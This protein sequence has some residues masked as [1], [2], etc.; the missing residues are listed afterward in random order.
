MKSC[1][2]DNCDRRHAAKGMCG[3]HYNRFKRYGDTS[4]VNPPHSKGG[5][6]MK[7]ETHPRWKGRDITYVSAHCRVS[8]HRGKASAHMCACG[9]AAQEWAYDYSDPNP[10]IGDSRGEYGL[11]YSPDVERYTPMCGKCHRQFDREAGQVPA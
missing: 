6:R 5:C 4:T 3:M 9:S 11:A 8:S 7:G 1:T 10:L 2:V